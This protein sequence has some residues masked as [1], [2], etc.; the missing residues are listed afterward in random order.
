MGEDQWQQIAAGY[1][2]GRRSKQEWVMGMNDIGPEFLDG[3]V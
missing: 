2:D 3:H 1:P